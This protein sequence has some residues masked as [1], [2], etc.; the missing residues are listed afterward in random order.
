M[1]LDKMSTD[2]EPAD[3]RLVARSLVRRLKRERARNAHLHQLL[4]ERNNHLKRLHG[5]VVKLR[6]GEEK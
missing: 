4:R 2:L 1:F 5:I 3:Y 6:K